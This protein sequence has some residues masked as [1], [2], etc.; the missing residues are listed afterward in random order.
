MSTYKN[1]LLTSSVILASVA[2]M[3]LAHAGFGLEARS[4]GMGNTSVATADI[5]TAALS[6]P[7][8]LSY[9]QEKEDFSLLLSGGMFIDDNADMI[10]A[11]DTLQSA[12]NNYVPLSGD[13]ATANAMRDS[14]IQMQG[15]A[16]AP[17][18]VFSAVVG[19]SFQEYSLA[20]SARNEIVTAAGLTSTTFTAGPA[21]DVTTADAIATEVA[22]G[23]HSV[24]FGG[25]S[26]TEIGLSGAKSFD[27]GG[28]KISVG[29]TPKIVSAE[30]FADV[31]V[32]ATNFDTATSNL[33]DTNNTTSLG[34]VVTFDLGLVSQISESTQVGLVIKNMLEDSLTNAAGTLNV[35]RQMKLGLAYRGD[36]FTAGVD[37]DLVE[38][39]PAVVTGTIVQSKAVQ[40][41]SIGLEFNAWDFMQLRLGMQ[42]NLA[43]NP[44]VSEDPL[45]TAG[46]GLWLGINV[47]VAV[48][49]S[50]NSVGGFAQAG[51][52]F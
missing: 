43:D 7:A 2:T 6:N 30:S 41:A 49:A 45:V 33:V 35:A 9:Q 48:V 20:F 38:I 37:V 39:D 10:D 25:A 16:L 29:L 18:G 44:G 26:L 15:N 23:T 42:Q 31:P 14:I 3:P 27:F 52:K 4:L 21:V 13:T 32:N 24:A 17:S 11:F 5:A 40:N 1:K 22:S 36:L 47:D 50:E 12:S 34:E 19:F 51:F 28:H 8:M 46:F